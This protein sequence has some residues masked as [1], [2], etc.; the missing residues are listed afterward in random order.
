MAK[1]NLRTRVATSDRFFGTGVHAPSVVQVRESSLANTA[2]ELSKF[3]Q[4]GGNA[5]AQ[6]G[7]ADFD[8]TA[9]EAEAAKASGAER[10]V[11]N[12]A[13]GYNSAWDALDAEDDFNLFKVAFK[14][15]L[16]GADAENM[17]EEAV[18]GL[19]DASSTKAFNMAEQSPAYTRV[20]APLLLDYNADVIGVHRAAVIKTVKDNQSAKTNRNLIARFDETGEFDYGYLAKMTSDLYE[21]KERNVT[22]EAIL[23]NFAITNGMPNVLR[24]SPQRYP[25]GAPT[26]LSF[27][28]GLTRLRVAIKQAENVKKTR[29]TAETKEN[30]DFIKQANNAAMIKAVQAMS[31]GSPLAEGQIVAFGNRPGAL[32]KDLLQLTSAFRSIRDDVQKQAADPVEL[33][34]ITSQVY[35]GGSSIRHILQ[36]LADGT[37]GNGLEA[38]KRMT[39]LMGAQERVNSQAERVTPQ[40][41]T[42]IDNIKAVYNPSMNGMFGKLDQRRATLQ[43]NALLDYRTAVL[44][45]NEDPNKAWERI[46]EQGDATLKRFNELVAIGDDDSRRPLNEVVNLWLNNEMTDSR[47]RG[48]NLKVEKIEALGLDTDDEIRLLN[49]I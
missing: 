45:G 4:V 38:V 29:E 30:E 13:I 25:S 15:K 22:Y 10:D 41:R 37:F 34:I 9:A 6:K 20:L 42:H 31:E 48:F 12:K 18:Q 32:A 33:A 14:E 39:S 26:P 3:L 27:G 43:A 8:R 16:R 2:A 7:A 23:I 47:L 35:A 1:K 44:E 24:N 5:L 19:F 11:L 21:G 17:E 49:T 28:E 46:R 40:M 36:A